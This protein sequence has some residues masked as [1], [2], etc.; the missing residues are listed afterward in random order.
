MIWDCSHHLSYAIRFL[1]IRYFVRRLPESGSVIHR[2][3]APGGNGRRRCWGPLVIFRVVVTI[4][5][6]KAVGEIVGT[7]V[8]NFDKVVIP[9]AFLI[10]LGSGQ[11]FDLGDVKDSTSDCKKR[12]VYCQLGDKGRNETYANYQQSNQQHSGAGD[13]AL[14][15]KSTRCNHKKPIEDEERLVLKTK[16]RW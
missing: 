14:P 9:A 5:I 6:M 7:V 12:L 4:E 11:E 13:R 10:E 16:L 3:P 2:S 1:N 8:A 15:T